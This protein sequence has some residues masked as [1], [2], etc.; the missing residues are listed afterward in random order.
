[1]IKNIT[2][3]TVNV[4]ELCILSELEVLALERMN[5][6]RVCKL[7]IEELIDSSLKHARMIDEK[8]V[9]LQQ[10]CIIIEHVLM[11]GIKSK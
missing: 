2:S 7:T 10:F 9:P 6:L 3:I 11:H 5:L 8:N 4:E 1:M